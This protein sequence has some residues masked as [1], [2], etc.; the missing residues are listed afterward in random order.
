M[1]HLSEAR[2]RAALPQDKAYKLF[3]TLG[4]YLKVE[5]SGGRLWRFRYRHAGVEK[6]L[7]L[8]RYP[9]ISLKRARDKRD[10]ARRQLAAGAD[11]AVQRQ[12]EKLAQAQT[13]GEIALEWLAMQ[14]K[15]FAPATCVKAQWTFSDLIIP[16]IGRRPIREITAPELLTLCRRLESRGKNETAHRTLQRCGQVFRYAVATGKALRDPTADL[17]GA[18]APIVSRNRAAIID[19]GE[20]A[21][22]MR[23]IWEYRGHPSTEAAF[24][25]SALLF[26]RPGELR[27]AEWQEFD[28]ERAEWRIPAHR[29]KMRQ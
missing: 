8:G 18:L 16:Y 19:P 29:M 6:L 25:L 17:R 10:E 26:V 1:P 13:F 27:K 3:D 23:A 5:T 11:P 2:V 4:L 22:L 7:S 14:R 20:I 21:K 24:K 9:K 15:R 28:L 12:A